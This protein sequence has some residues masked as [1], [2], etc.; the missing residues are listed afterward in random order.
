MDAAATDGRHL[1]C[2]PR[3]KASVQ[4]RS[5]SRSAPPAGPS[6][7]S[8]GGAVPS[9]PLPA[10]RSPPL[11]VPSA[12][13]TDQGWKPG[14]LRESGC[15]VPRPA[16]D[17]AGGVPAGL[18]SS[19]AGGVGNEPVWGKACL[20]MQSQWPAPSPP[21]PGQQAPESLAKPSR[22]LVHAQPLTPGVPS[23]SAGGPRRSPQVPARPCQC[24][25]VQPRG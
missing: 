11:P 25:Q 12:L 3:K 13:D 17:A 24:L 21:A 20:G 8:G 22:P 18:W 19:G 23:L 10:P 5:W 4:L 1:T 16:G 7:R 14:G 15:S 2:R 9:G 6:L